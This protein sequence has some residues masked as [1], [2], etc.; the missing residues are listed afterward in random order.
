MEKRMSDF[1]LGP[2]WDPKSAPGNL[3]SLSTL[4]RPHPSDLEDA[5]PGEYLAQRLCDYIIEKE[6]NGIKIG[7]KWEAVERAEAVEIVAGCLSKTLRGGISHLSGGE[8]HQVLILYNNNITS[9]QISK[10]SLTAIACEFIHFLHN[11]QNLS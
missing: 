1:P 8:G 5:K 11:S 6:A 7:S 9:S 4:S 2:S 3:V 10:L